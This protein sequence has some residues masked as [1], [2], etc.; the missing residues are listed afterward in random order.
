MAMSHA[1]PTYSQLY[2]ITLIQFWTEDHSDRTQSTLTGQ[3]L[4]YILPRDAQY[5]SHIHKLYATVW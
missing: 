1:S 4:L 3:G 2:T 5:V